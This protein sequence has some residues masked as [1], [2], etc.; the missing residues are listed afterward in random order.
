MENDDFN[1]NKNNLVYIHDKLK[2]TQNNFKISVEKIKKCKQCEYSYICSGGCRAIS[3][4]HSGN[5][6]SRHPYC[7][8]IKKIIKDII[9]DLDSG[10]L[11]D[12]KD[13][14]LQGGNI[15]NKKIF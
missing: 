6:V 15:K 3:Y 13:F 4:H 5:L 11:D 2:K 10:L 8:D 1:V 14:L 12:Y 9:D 7:K